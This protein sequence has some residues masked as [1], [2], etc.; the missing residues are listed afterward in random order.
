M[1]REVSDISTRALSGFWVNKLNEVPFSHHIPY[2]MALRN[3]LARDTQRNERGPARKRIG[4]TR[5]KRW[6]KQ[7]A[8]AVLS[9]VGVTSRTEE[10]CQYQG[11]IIDIGL[12]QVDLR[13]DT[14]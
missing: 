14:V 10:G 3:S 4:D 6:A 11:G 13:D 2:S 7:R 1:S 5:R 12:K 9:P 8:E